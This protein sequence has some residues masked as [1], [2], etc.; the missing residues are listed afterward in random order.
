MFIQSFYYAILQS[1]A[2]FKNMPGMFFVCYKEEYFLKIQVYTIPSLLYLIYF[3]IV[4]YFSHP[5]SFARS[6]AWCVHHYQFRWS[7]FAAQNKYTFCAWYLEQNDSLLMA[8]QN[9][10][11]IKSYSSMLAHYLGWIRTIRIVIKVCAF[12]KRWAGIG[13]IINKVSCSAISI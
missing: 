3:L 12:L 9:W 6:I 11:R 1:T 10:P 5:F 2:D 8:T 7:I 4:L 13:S